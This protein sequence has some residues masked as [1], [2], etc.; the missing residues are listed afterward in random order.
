[1]TRKHAPLLILVFALAAGCAG[2]SKLAE[3]SQEKLANGDTWRA[4]NLATR[5]LD[6]EPGNPQARAAAA[7]AAGAIAEDWRRRI[8]ALADADSLQAA[9]QVLEFVSF[10]VTAARY[11]TV[12]V[13]SAWTAEERSLR[14][15]AARI[16]YREGVAALDARR[17]KQAYLHFTDV[18][19]YV[20]GY[21]DAAQLAAR[22]F[23]K[24][25]TKVAFLPFAVASGSLDLGRDVSQA[26]RDDLARRLTPPDSRF[27][28]VLIGPDVDRV[29]T[30]S[31]SDQLT[32][33]V[34]VRIGRRAGADRVVW[35]TIGDVNA[36]TH[37]EVFSDMI[38]H[39]VTRTDD[40]GNKVVDWVA[41]PILVVARVRT[42]TVDVAYDLIATGG[43]ATISHQA[44]QRSV[45]ARALWT[46]FIPRGD[47]DDYALVSDAD[48]AS[49]P[50]HAREAESRW[51]LVAGEGTSLRQVL[52]ARRS[53]GESA[54]YRHESLS[55]FF[56]GGRAFVFLEDLPPTEDLAF[57]ALAHS[58]GPLAD[59]LLR[60]D[61]TDDVDLGMAAAGPER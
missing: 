15:A 22:A 31:E 59:D 45:T 5:A 42:V 36:K 10:R 39:R 35:G 43:A 34:A 2:P 56:P 23:D 47:L 9:D 61:A 28:R 8:R 30:V 6:K 38:T 51:R 44:G 53:T 18:A 7:S 41:V 54:H 21:R 37:T 32:R 26:W 40:D 3:R 13:D 1:M 48:R 50:Q 25:L 60:L 4:W 27:T 16:H 52:E 33:Q 11:A 12:P 14:R 20:S 29:M 24:A 49:D 58:W 57:A 46:T 17:P 55:L 19:R